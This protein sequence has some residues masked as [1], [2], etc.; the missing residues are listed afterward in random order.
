MSVTEKF[1]VPGFS[2]V[3]HAEEIAQQV[4]P[5]AID[6][7]PRYAA[8]AKRS[9]TWL[10]STLSLDERIVEMMTTP[11]SLT[12]RPELRYLHPTVQQISI[13]G[14][15]YVKDA[16]AS[17][18][19]I[20]HVR[21]IVAFNRKLIPQFAAASVPI[22]AGTDALNPG[23]V[24]GFSLHDELV[25]L[26]QA[27]LTAQQA[28]EAA[29]RRPAEFLGTIEDRGVIAPGKRADLV[30][31]DANPLENIANTRRIAGVIVNGMFYSRTELNARMQS[32][33]RANAVGE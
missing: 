21:N 31:L 11:A 15:P 25:A 2:M 12:Q 20:E 28:L 1:F 26:V 13:H 22:V 27:G 24:P 7:I 10:T 30:M 3:A 17:P 9:D 6:M 19:L 23:V 18:E 5:P 33:Q 8:W 14:N 29:T 16:S 32:L 4:S